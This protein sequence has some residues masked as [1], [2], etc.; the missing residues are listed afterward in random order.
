VVLVT[1]VIFAVYLGAVDF[2]V[3]R[4]YTWLYEVVNKVLS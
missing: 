3:A 1:S 4:G 2:L